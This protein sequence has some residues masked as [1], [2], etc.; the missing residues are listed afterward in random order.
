MSIVADT[1]LVA[2]NGWRRYISMVTQR[3][4]LEKG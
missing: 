3:M 2:V 1:E 4:N